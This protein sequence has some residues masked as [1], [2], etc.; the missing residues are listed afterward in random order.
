MLFRSAVLLCSDHGQTAVHT[1][2]KIEVPGAL[3]TAS[4]RAGM[5]YGD[6]PRA[7][8]EALADEP[9]I[10]VVT[11]L[12]DGNI[13]VRRGGDE[14][15]A[16]LDDYLDGHERVRRALVNPNAGE[17]IFAAADGFEFIDLGGGHHAGGGSHGSLA[18]SDSE[19]PMLSVGLGEPPA[20]ILGIKETIVA[21][22]ATQRP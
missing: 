15:T 5:V 17:V 2:A 21:H 6:D 19:V 7:L 1:P 4:N 22:F 12:E 9:S 11:F 3:V 18:A 14:D 8:A 20:S 10:D 16:I 13:V